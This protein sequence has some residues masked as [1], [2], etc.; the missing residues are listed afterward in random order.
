MFSQA[1][2][3]ETNCG[4]AHMHVHFMHPTNEQLRHVNIF[5]NNNYNLQ[6]ADFQCIDGIENYP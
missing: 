3:A 1:N 5:F 4:I 2:A 6:S